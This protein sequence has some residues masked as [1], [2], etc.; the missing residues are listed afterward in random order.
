MSTPVVL[1][2]ALPLSSA[3]WSAQVGALRDRA[4]ALDS[5]GFGGAPLGRQEPSLSLLA[6]DVARALDERGVRGAVIVGASMGGYVAMEFLRRHPG[7]VLGLGLIGTR[8]DADSDGTR[9][10]RLRMAADLLDAERRSTVIAATTPA[11]LGRTTRDTRPDLLSR[12]RAWVDDAAP[13]AVAWAQAAVAARPDSVDVLRR[14]RVPTVVI[15]GAED[16]LVP[17]DRTADL[18]AAL[19][20]SRVVSLPGVGHLPPLEAPGAVSAALLALV[21]EVTG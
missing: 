10:T 3:M 20:R 9:S 5:R 2:H 18:V 19:P 6:D 7:R 21:E 1:L 11:L 15:A 4:L 16:E 14:V 8:A 13:E 12:L 17:P